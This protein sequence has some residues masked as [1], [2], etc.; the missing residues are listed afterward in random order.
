MNLLL[1]LL[2][3][4]T[5]SYITSNVAAKRGRDRT[6]W[7]ILGFFFG[8]F[9]LAFV[10]FLPPLNE[11]KEEPSVKASDL[12]PPKPIEPVDPFGDY[13]WHLIDVN[14]KQKGPLG[15]VDLHIAW[16]DGLATAES[17]VWHEGMGDWKRVSEISGLE[18]RLRTGKADGDY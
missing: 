17:Y 8:I 2:V 13:R 10:F 4:L 12:V 15:I 1:T 3:V 6:G 9:A 7:F 14:G 11:K 16:D 5:I 18:L